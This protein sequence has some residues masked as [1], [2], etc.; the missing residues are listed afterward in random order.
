VAQHTNLSG[1]PA[2]LGLGSHEHVALVGGGGKTTLLHALGR[3][4]TGTR[5][6]TST[7]KMAARQHATLPVWLGPTDHEISTAVLNGPLMVWAA[8]R[9]DKAVGVSP[10]RCDQL[11]QLVDHVIVEADGSRQMPFKAP[12]PF[13]PVV[14]RSTTM[15]V[16]VIGARAL[17]KVIADACHRPLRVAA[18][19]DCSPYQRLTPAAAAR[20]LAHPDGLR[21]AL[22]PGARFAIAITQLDEAG[23]DHINE[24]VEHLER[25]AFGGTIVLVRD[26]SW[27]S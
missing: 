8:T 14:P 3:S 21:R 27:C 24:L 23:P 4:L 20:V 22:V 6:L 9:A 7:T 10:E 1:L 11:F 25:S 16:S 19:A 13:E 12:N 2:A 26:E 15:L 5:V 18:L 17:G